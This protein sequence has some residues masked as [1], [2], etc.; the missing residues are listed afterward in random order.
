VVAWRDVLHEGPVPALPPAELREAR[1]AFLAGEGWGSR[2]A[3]LAGLEARDRALVEADHAVLWFEHDL[4]DQ[5]Q[6]V[7]ALALAPDPARLE[8]VNV[9]RFLGTLAAA[10]LEALWPGRRPVTVED[11][12]VARAAW[13]AVRAPEPTAV[14]ALVAVVPSPLPFLHAA[15][16]R[17]LEELPWTRDGLSRSERQLL[18]ALADGARTPSAAFAAAQE[19]EEAPFL[20]DAWAFRR[21]AALGPLVEEHGDG[22]LALTDA[23][24]AVLAGEADRIEL[25]GIDR[26][27][28]GTH[29]RRGAVWRWDGTRV[30]RG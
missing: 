24:R 30:V 10:D 12:A 18:D 23:G 6:L 13:D 27:L 20:G 9:D 29:L 14:A 7:Q 2:D 26:W 19:R 21:L 5:L 25:L 1:A 16:R 4:Y 15:L 3:I 28:G 11:V 8:L 17:F 22:A